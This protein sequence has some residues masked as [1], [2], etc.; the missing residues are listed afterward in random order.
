MAV[1]LN[2]VQETEK[3]V[4]K[5]YDI[6]FGEQMFTEDDLPSVEQ[7]MRKIISKELSTV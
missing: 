5:H 6:D 4:E 7:E 2:K 3:Q 1:L